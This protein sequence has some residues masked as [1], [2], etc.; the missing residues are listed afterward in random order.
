MFHGEGVEPVAGP[1]RGEA[2]SQS[3]PLQSRT[4]AEAWA[5]SNWNVKPLG[6]PKWEKGLRGP[7]VGQRSIC[8][9]Y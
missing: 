1:S 5:E 6:L 3:S 7:E 4:L 8:G 9:A 2:G